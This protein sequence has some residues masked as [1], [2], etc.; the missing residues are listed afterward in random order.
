MCTY[1]NALDQ[2]NAT[3]RKNHSIRQQSLERILRTVSIA[4][5]KAFPSGD[6]LV[7]EPAI[8]IRR[9]VTSGENRD[10]APDRVPK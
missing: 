9:R 8:K 6:R 2:Q 4:N 1:E 7:L 10:S 3:L 5:R